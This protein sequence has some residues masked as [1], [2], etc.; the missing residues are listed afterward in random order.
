MKNSYYVYSI[1]KKGYNE[2]QKGKYDTLDEARRVAINLEYSRI[3]GKDKGSTE[4]RQ[5][6][7]D[8]EDEDCTNF[9]YNTFP[10]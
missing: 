8:I 7:D 3:Q 9:D 2:W 6:V 1:D 5:Y 4:I 10:F